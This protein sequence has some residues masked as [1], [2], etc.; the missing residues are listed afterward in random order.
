MCLLCKAAIPRAGKQKNRFP[1]P[2]K[3]HWLRRHLPKAHHVWCNLCASS[4]CT[5]DNGVKLSKHRGLG[6]HLRAMQFQALFCE[7]CG[8]VD[9]ASHTGSSHKTCNFGTNATVLM[10]R[11]GPIYTVDRG[12]AREAN[13]SAL[14]AIVK[15]YDVKNGTMVTEPLCDPHLS[16]ITDL[17]RKLLSSQPKIVATEPCHVC[18][19]AAAFDP[20]IQISDGKRIHLQWEVAQYDLRGCFLKEPDIKEFIH[21]S[22]AAETD[23]AFLKKHY[24]FDRIR[25]GFV[26]TQQ[27]DTADQQEI[28]AEPELDSVDFL[29]Q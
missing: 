6:K 13:V 23:E 28:T 2:I 15:Q 5:E 16:E 8:I 11:K 17:T 7:V 18:T 1:E 24:V 3:D 10:S 27:K 19:I 26:R 21:I 29:T 25:F 12:G 9:P 4:V 20:T 22:E 14:M